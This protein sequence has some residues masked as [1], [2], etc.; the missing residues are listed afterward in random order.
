MVYN[1][2]AL[3]LDSGIKDVHQDGLNKLLDKFQ[4]N[5]NDEDAEKHFLFVVEECKNAMFAR[6]NDRIHKWRDYFSK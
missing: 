4:I 1:L 6:I 5:L 3:M 2:T